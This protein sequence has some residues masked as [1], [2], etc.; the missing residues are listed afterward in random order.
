MEN[1]AQANTVKFH[2]VGFSDNSMILF[3]QRSQILSVAKS[4]IRKI[5]LKYGFQSERPIV[6]AMFGIVLIGAGFYFIVHLVLHTL[7]YRIFYVD[8]I[9]SLLLLPAGGWFIVDGFRKR[10]YFEVVLDNDKRKFPL[11]KNPDKSE[12]QKFIKIASQLGYSVDST[13]LNET[14]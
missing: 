3:D 8:D 12:L 14:T 2:N 7:V 11:G 5:N 6:E 10:F 1:P 13:I 4:D 9:L